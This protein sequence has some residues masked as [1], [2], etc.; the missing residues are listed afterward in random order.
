[1]ATAFANAVDSALVADYLAGLG[2]AVACLASSEV[3]P[4]DLFLLDAPSAHRLGRGV[5]ARKADSAIFLPALVALR[6]DESADPWLTAGFDGVVRLPC[7]KAELKANLAIL[8]RLRRNSQDLA[9]AGEERYQAIF[10]STGT[11]TIVVEHDTTIIMANRECLWV[12]GYGAEELVGTSWT[13][14]VAPDSLEEMRRYH[15]ARRQAADAPSQYETRLIDKS[16]RDRVVLLS[17][18]VI[19]GTSQSVV[20]MVDLTERRAAEEAL[21]ESELRNR[22]IAELVSDYAYIF[23]VDAEGGLHGEWLTESFSKVFGMTIETIDARGGWQSLVYPED[24]Q[25]AVEHART[26]AAGRA[27]VC[28]M[29]WVTAEGEVRWL[30]DYARPV[31][32]PS[33]QR[34][35]RVFGASQDITERKAAEQQKQRL[36]EQLLQAR[37]MASVGRLAG[38]VAH[39]FNNMLSVILGYGEILCAKLDRNDPLRDDVEQIV[40]AGQRSADLTRQLLAFS[41]KQTLQPVVLDVNDALRNVEKMLRR[42]IGEDIALELRLSPQLPSVKVDPGQLEQVIVNLAANARDAMPV[43]GTLLIET[44]GVTLDDAYAREHVGVAV[45]DYVMIAVTDTGCGMDP[46]TLSQIF[47]PFFTT[48]GEGRGTGLGLSTVYGTV[49]QSGGTIWAYSEPGRG[50]TF[51]VYLLATPDKPATPA[52]QPTLGVQSG[53]GERILIVEDEEAVRGLLEAVLTREGYEVAVAADGAEALQ[54]I[55]EQGLTPELVITDVVMPGLRGSELVERI[56][57]TYPSVKVLFM[58]GYTDNA[59]VHHGILDPGTPFIQKPFSIRDIA[60]KVRQLLQD[61][62]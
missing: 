27:D 60:A 3:T 1:V 53:C 22:V 32:D 2:Y 48:K 62:P 18:A 9:R 36:E 57:R 7:A 11:A 23:R 49:T 52:G 6:R 37:K 44:A 28:E 38:G 19:P 51:K 8:L 58:S 56:R 15:E 47:D 31:Y 17:V 46:E 24:L 59:I 30:R 39:D 34:V 14:Y 16:G 13:A 50:S 45:G 10:Q 55:E 41:R 26:V 61:G 33:G 5:L 20:S 12:T 4:A 40:K 25:I 35:V 29:R 21:R 54:R 43:G 42:L